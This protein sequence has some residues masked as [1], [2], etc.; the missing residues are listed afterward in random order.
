MFDWFKSERQKWKIPINRAQLVSTPTLPGFD[1][2]SRE[3][4]EKALPRGVL[5]PRL[6]PDRER[7]NYWMSPNELMRHSWV[8]GQLILG[9]IGG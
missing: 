8:P 7:V 5:I 2:R 1:T 9:K 4:Y 3:L 6:E